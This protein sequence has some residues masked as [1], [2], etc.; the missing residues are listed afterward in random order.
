MSTRILVLKDGVITP[1]KTSADTTNIINNLGVVDL[2][3]NQTIGGIK[4]FNGGFA[5]PT[6][7]GT[8]IG[9]VWRN[10]DTLEYKDST[11]VTKIL[12]NSAGNLSNLSNRQTSL[13]NLVGT[14]AASRLLRSDGTNVTL[15]QVGLTTDVIGVLPIVNG[16]TNSSTQNWVDLTTAQSIAGNKTFTGNIA[17]ISSGMIGLGNVNNTSDLSKPISTLTQSALNLKA[18]LV[19]GFIP[20]SQLPSYV[21][22]VLEFA[23][24]AAFPATG[25]SGKIYVA[26]NTNLTYRWTGSVYSNMSPSLAL[27]ITSSTAYRGDFG[28]IAYNHSQ[29]IAGN[30]HGLT[31]TLIGLG[32]VNNTADANKPVS[33]TQQTALNLKANLLSPSFTTPNLG[34]PSAGILTNATGLSLTTGITGILAPTNGGANSS[35]Y[36]DMTTAQTVLS[37]KSFG[38]ELRVVHSSYP[39]IVF[40]ATSYGVDLKKFQMFITPEGDFYFASLNDAESSSNGAFI[41]KSN[42]NINFPSSTQSTSTTTGGVIF[43]GGVGVNGNGHFA[44]SLQV[45]GRGVFAVQNTH[46]AISPN[47]HITGIHSGDINIDVSTK[48]W[49]FITSLRPDNTAF[50]IQL[51]LCDT[52][53]GVKYRNL[54]NGTWQAWTTIL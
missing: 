27:G 37:I 29:I 15:S 17:G 53:I 16:G 33:V 22:D 32:N 42:G 3:N 51:A 23:N 31:T 18:D 21:D 41:I 49:H 38:P 39:K 24:L 1:A 2:V 5:L 44:G 46:T 40:N 13:N 12:L 20:S 14:Q 26:L 34:T 11:N 45:N 43:G 47:S 28:D 52:Q 25:E 54:F 30:P 50:G 6:N 36:V 7:I 9:T 4:T 35:T 19:G 8:T 10:V 48:G